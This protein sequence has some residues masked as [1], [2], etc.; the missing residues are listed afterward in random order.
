MHKIFDDFY[1]KYLESVS[2]QQKSVEAARRLIASIKDGACSMA[3]VKENIGNTANALLWGIKHGERAW[4]TLRDFY[5]EF[6]D[7]YG[8]LVF[9]YDADWLETRVSEEL[10]A[11]DIEAERTAENWIHVKLPH[12][13]TQFGS[14]KSS[15]RVWE[16]L[17]KALKKLN[18]EHKVCLE[19][20]VI[21]FLQHISKYSHAPLKDNDNISLKYI[22]NLLSRNFLADDCLEYLDIHICSVFDDAD[23]VDVFL[24]PEADFS[25]FY[26]EYKMKFTSILK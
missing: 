17:D 8:P 25:E 14:I 1:I 22:V 18:P 2:S 13:I 23:Y 9:K 16:P 5:E 21:V 4:L 10:V 7:T 6:V 12:F 19:K 26:K 11:M 3:D 20:C 24:V 15:N